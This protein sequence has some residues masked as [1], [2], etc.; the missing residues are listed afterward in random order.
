FLGSEIVAALIMALIQ[1][2][3]LLL[4]GWAVFRVHINGNW[5]YMAFIVVLGAAA[6]QAAGFLIASVAKTLKTAEMAANAITFPMMFLSG[7][8]FPLAILPSFLAV[9]AKCLPLYY[10]GD[11]LRKVM[12]QGKG[13]GDVWLDIIVIGGMGLVCFIA[14]IKLFRWE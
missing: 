13:L 12:I 8:F 2:A 10:L 1:A 3:I 4:V 5:L 14:A 7:V 6:F 9:I 11:A